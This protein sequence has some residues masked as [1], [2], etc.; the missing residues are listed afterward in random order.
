MPT[1]INPLVGPAPAEVPLSRSPLVRVVAQVRFPMIASIEKAD[2]I[3]PFQEAVR[4]AYPTLRPEQSHSVAL[5]AQGVLD[6]RASTMW[7]FHDASG[8]WRLTLT[9]TFLALETQAYL[10]RQDFLARWGDALAALAAHIDPK[11]IERLGVRYINRLSEAQLQELP[12]LVRPEVCGVLSTPLASQAQHAIT[13]VNF[14][15]PNEAGHVMARWGR[16]PAGSTVDPGAI[17]ARDTPGWLLDIDAFQTTTRELDVQ[18]PLAQ[19]EAFCARIYAVFRWMVTDA[20]LRQC[21]GEP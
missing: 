1:D 19:S 14:E 13:E 9:Q 15:L 21:G 3:A 4:S 11:I 10:S 6:A 17:E 7:R 20:L 12:N 18:A 5:G 2:F 16:I 8:A